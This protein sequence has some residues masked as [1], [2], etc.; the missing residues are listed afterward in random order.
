MEKD[1]G[2][3]QAK[4]TTK[5]TFILFG[6]ASLLGSNAILTEL[7]FFNVFLPS[8]NVYVTFNFLNYI[9][10]I[11]FQFLLMWKKDFL[12]LKTQL[13]I[14]IMGSIVFLIIL[15]MFTMILEQDSKQNIIITGI[16]V[17]LMGFINALCSGGFFNLVS[18]FPLEMIVSLSSGQGFSGISM[19]VL[20]YIVLFSI[21]NDDENNG[22]RTKE[23]YSIR[24]WVFFGLS[25]LILIISLIVLLIS[26]NTEYF[27]Y[28]LNKSNNK[29]NDT[30]IEL[31]DE[32]NNVNSA[33]IDSINEK[34]VV[35]EASFKYLFS[36]LWD[37]DLL[38]VY[39]YIVTFT[40]FPNATINQQLFKLPIDYNLNTN[41]FIYNIF[42]T[43]G[44]S[45]VSKFKPTKKLSSIVILGRSVLLFTI[46]FNYFC[47]DKL[48]WNLYFTSIILIINTA[49]LA[50]TNGMGTT[51]CF[52]IA[53]NEVENE[54]KGQAGNSLSF[55]LILGIFLGSCS[56]FG[57]NAIINTFKK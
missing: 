31:L 25:S 35:K 9:L 37:L 18:N 14:G 33:D 7:A 21:P 49:L 55:F 46:V 3:P 42:D 53:P 22:E 39:I 6:I 50:T 23:I 20:Q 27:Q 54:Y 12:K 30:T 29:S 43:I 13:I 34:V 40:L 47:Q 52:G 26:Y 8:M 56:A 28:Y 16:L 24:G 15:P 17:F 45:I 1:L 2:V 41:I 11:G 4:F 5:L 36:K 44:R 48:E 51:L 19:N 38:M 10:N 32:K 57:T